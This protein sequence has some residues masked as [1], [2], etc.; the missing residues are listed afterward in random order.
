MNEMGK[1][2]HAVGLN[3]NKPIVFIHATDLLVMLELLSSASPNDYRSR[4]AVSLCIYHEHLVSSTYSTVCL[5][6]EY[7]CHGQLQDAES[8]LK[9]LQSFSFP[10]MIQVNS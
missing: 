5:L 8:E 2:E 1:R 10:T 7:K 4:A 3:A 9:V 6:R